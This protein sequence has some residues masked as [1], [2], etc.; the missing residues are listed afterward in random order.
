MELFD[1]IYEFGFCDKII[2]Y[3]WDQSGTYYVVA[4]GFKLRA[5]FLH[6]PPEFWIYLDGPSQLD[7]F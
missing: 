6:Q 1:F 5:I 7:V 3:R 4:T 2:S